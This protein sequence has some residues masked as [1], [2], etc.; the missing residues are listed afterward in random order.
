MLKLLLQA[1]ARYSLSVLG[2]WAYSF[3]TFSAG[4]VLGASKMNQIEVNIRDHVHGSAGVTSTFASIVL[5][6]AIQ[7]GTNLELGHASDTT[8]ARIAAGRASIEGVAIVRGPGSATDNAIPRFDGT[9]GDLIQSSNAVVNDNGRVDS[10]GSDAGFAMADRSSGSGNMIVYRDSDISRLHDTEFGAGADFFTFNPSTGA[11]TFPGTGTATFSGALAAASVT[12]THVATQAEQ[13]SA[14]ATDKIVTPGRQHFHPGHPKC[15]GFVTFSGGVP[16]LQTSYNI[17]SI[18]D[19]A[20]GFLTWTI[21]TD[22]SSANWAPLMTVVNDAVNA[23]QHTFAASMAAGSV[24]QR[25]FNASHVNDDPDG[26]SFMGL[27]DQA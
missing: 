26:A 23:G 18:T 24:I 11:Y 6:G 8:F 19:T 5:S 4:E 21:A 20:T 13:E 17:T 14:S 10:N 7:V 25:T 15:W 16:T 9:T 1:L 3:Q 22:F 2:C 27:G 12:G